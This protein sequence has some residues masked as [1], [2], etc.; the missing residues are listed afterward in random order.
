MD[1]PQIFKYLDSVLFSFILVIA[2]LVFCCLSVSSTI[3]LLSCSLNNVYFELLF[4]MTLI[5]IN[6]KRLVLY[7]DLLFVFFPY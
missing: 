3:V 6:I 1:F 2:M 4:I 5:T 7:F